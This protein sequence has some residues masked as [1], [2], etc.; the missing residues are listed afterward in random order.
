MTPEALL[1]AGEHDT[2]LAWHVYAHTVIGERL[3]GV[4]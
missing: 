3:R 4:D 2:I 1:V